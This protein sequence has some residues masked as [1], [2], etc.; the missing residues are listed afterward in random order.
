MSN[1]FRVA[2]RK[3]GPFE[4]TIEKI[5][6]GFCKESGCSMKL[7]ALPMDLS[8]LYEATLGKGDGLNKGDW[9]VTNINTDWIM[10]AD[11]KNC[12]ED[13]TPWISSNPPDDYP[14]G[15]S[16]SLLSMQRFNQRILGLP[17]HDGPECLIYR[18]DLFND[19]KEKEAFN[20]KYKRELLPP[21]TWKE[22]HEVARFFNRPT[23]NLYGTAFALYPDGHN[24]VF[25]FS[26]QLWT[27]GGELVNGDEQ[28]NINTPEAED[29]LKFYREIVRDELA[30]HPGSVNFDSV[31]L[32]SAFANGEISMMVNWFGFASICEVHHESKVKGCVDIT[33]IPAGRSGK[34]FSL[35]VYW[36][37][38]IGKGSKY[39][40][41]AYDFIRYAV[42]ANNDKLLTLEGGIGCRKSTW[43]DREINEK[44]SYYHKLGLLH[45][46]ARTLPQKSNWNEISEVLD[47]MVIS[48]LST[49]R[50]EKELL[51]E[52]QKEIDQLKR[53]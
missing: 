51:K 47:Q 10:E 37:Y 42:N 24:T 16:D 22:F 35:N 29:G 32:G 9:D 43:V 25:D 1:T 30:M 4:S 18:R 27:R 34:G 39:K 11:Q 5:W 46:N 28:I 17:F 36:L 52:A 7:E 33:N 8:D 44:I 40:K 41:I 2:V 48:L 53:K 23:Q 13:L 14:E 6:K 21:A 50:T 12:L 19:P 15:W 45:E 31:Q 49:D 26:L 3:F 20:M 38:A